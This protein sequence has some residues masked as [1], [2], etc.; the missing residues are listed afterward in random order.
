M[1]RRWT[2]LS[3]A[4]RLVLLQALG[5]VGFIR[6]ALWVLPFARLRTLLAKIGQVRRPSPNRL[7]PARLAWAVSVT[8]RYVPC[9]TCLTQA[10]AAELLLRWAGYRGE[11]QIG[12]AK[13]ANGRLLAH[14]WL[15]YEGIIII[16]GYEHSKFTPLPPV[17]LWDKKI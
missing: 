5:I 10:L 12:V 7:A 17:D 2:R 11:L 8:S 16:G 14:A 13:L 15:E 6:L 1:L 4:D 3:C 9:A